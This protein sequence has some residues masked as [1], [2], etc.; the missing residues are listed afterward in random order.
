M[1]CITYGGQLPLIQ[2]GGER[3]ALAELLA[4]APVPLADGA[5]VAHDAR[6][7]L[8]GLTAIGTTPDSF[9]LAEPVLGTLFF[10][11]LHV[12]G[13]RFQMRKLFNK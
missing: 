12:L 13:Y 8:A 10:Y 7:D 9:L 6:V 3:L 4:F 1:P 11:S 2:F 5:E